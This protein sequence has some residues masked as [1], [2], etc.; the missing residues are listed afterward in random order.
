[1]WGS[2]P[3]GE[4]STATSKVCAKAAVEE[5]KAETASPVASFMEILPGMVRSCAAVVVALRICHLDT[6]RKRWCLSTRSHARETETA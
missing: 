6:N 5:S 4:A 2:R 1:M 3:E